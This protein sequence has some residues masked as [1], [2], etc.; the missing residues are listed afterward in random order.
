M[1]AGATIVIG[2]RAGSAP[3]SRE[4]ELALHLA[5]LGR[6]A[7]FVGWIRLDQRS[8]AGQQTRIGVLVS[9]D[10]IDEVVKTLLETARTGKQGD[11]H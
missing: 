7:V 11:G 6:H 2:G 8:I 9:D 5:R 3:R 10:M 1:R 4:E